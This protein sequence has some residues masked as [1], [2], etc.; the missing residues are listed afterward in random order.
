MSAL[1]TVSVVIPSW[2]GA[3]HLRHCLDSLRQVDYPEDGLEVIVVDNGS[4]DGSRGLLESEYPWV[5]L[6][7]LEENLGFAAACNEGARAATSDCVAFLNNDMRVEPHW[8]RG[9][10][11]GLD[12]ASGYVC[13][14]GVILDWEG[15]R[16]G[17]A[18]GWV[19]FHGSAGQEHF[20]D[21]MREELVEDG[22]D[23]P[24]ACGGSML[25]DRDVFLDL[26]GFDPSYFAYY[27]DVD[28]GWRLWLAGYKVRLAGTARCFHRHHGTG[29]GIPLYRR[30]LLTERNA[31]FTLI[32]NVGDENLASVLAPALF[33][34]TKRA[35]MSSESARDS[36]DVDSSDSAETETVKR[37]SLAR[38]HAASDVL[39]DLP[40]LLERRREVQRR[41]RRDDGEIF[42]L[43]G[44]PFAL[45]SHD[46]AYVEA[47]VNLRAAFGLD[48]LFTRQRATRILVVADGESDRLR[49]VARTAGILS[50]VAFVSPG[51]DGGVVEELVAESD[52]VIAAA[53]TAHARTIAEQTVGL[54]VVDLADG[55]AP[56]D[57]DLLRRGDVFLTSSR[58]V[59]PPL[60]PTRNG[61]DRLPIVVVSPAGD[62]PSP[63]REILQEPW[64]WRR[65]ERG[66]EEI[67][68]PEDLQQL[69]RLWREHYRDGGTRN[70]TLRLVRRATPSRVERSVRRL[71]RRPQL[72][73]LTSRSGGA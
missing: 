27:E 70:R 49:E 43:F 56:V 7:S 18:G 26:G 20:L 65:H 40:Q 23:L 5:R 16:I 3:E 1:P 41:R 17:F 68:I 63:L 61:D 4:T 57:P 31:L 36:F 48:R 2:N 45:L 42:A 8:L 62:G 51:R 58:D 69:L 33:L 25:I 35:A 12:P 24:F 6:V 14:G 60:R 46:E 21:P 54:L 53:T 28:L 52:L 55:E 32:K 22:R 64:R 44:R 19:T 72:K 15:A 38:L 71:L 66:A 67:A 37:A 11:S 13:V 10:V 50:E 59:E 34:L 47:S 29:S 39:A 73:D 9:L 30:T